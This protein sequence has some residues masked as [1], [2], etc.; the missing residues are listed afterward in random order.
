[1]TVLIF[2]VFSYFVGS[3]PFSVII[4]KLRGIELSESGTGNLGATNVAI[5]TGFRWGF[6][7]MVLDVTKG[8]VIIL[9]ARIF[10]GLDIIIVLAGLLAIIG[11]NFSVFL[12]FKGGKG[13]ATT[14]GVYLMIDP[15]IAFIGLVSYGIIYLITRR[16][17]FTTLSM[18]TLTPF[19]F[20][21]FGLPIVY[22]IFGLVA[23]MLSFY[24]HRGN[25][26]KMIE[27]GFKEEVTFKKDEGRS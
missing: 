16:F 3:I 2:L 7:S 23:A 10:F 21:I 5:T 6:I 9:L 19:L 4:S 1:M 11:H 8:S 15:L 25:V 26:K 17:I 20:I 22:F 14:F 12:G 18:L 27:T 13:L 24:T